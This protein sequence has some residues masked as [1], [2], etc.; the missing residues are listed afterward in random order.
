[1]FTLYV[2]MLCLIGGPV[3]V[4][5]TGDSLT[6]GYGG[7]RLQNSFNAAG[8]PAAVERVA[9]GGTTSRKYT[10][11]DPDACTGA[12]RDFTQDV[13]VLDPDAVV[14]MLG[15]NDAFR[16]VEDPNYFAGYQQDL[17][18][19]FT[20]LR[21]AVNERGRHPV[22]VVSTLIPVLADPEVDA[23]VADVYNPWLRNVTGQFGFAALD[24]H[25]E[26]QQEPNWP[27]FYSDGIH[28][29]ANNAAGYLWMADRVR[30]RVMLALE[31]QGCRCFADLDCDQQVGLSDL[32]ILLGAFGG[33]AAGDINQDG[34]TDL[35]DLAGLLSMFGLQCPDG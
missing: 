13:L 27:S 17:L 30:D 35:S 32:A 31:E 14:F 19:V 22:V 16:S 6:N 28:L 5:P 25:A 11:Q 29:W 21:A 24:L 2:V 12:P 8:Y 33:D 34:V 3:K 20:R 18:G 1:M 9:C 7:G 10:A 26:I 23:L 15:T 4:V